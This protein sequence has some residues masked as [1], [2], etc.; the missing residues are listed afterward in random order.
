MADEENTALIAWDA[1]CTANG[2]TVIPELE[3]EKQMEVWQAVYNTCASHAV[4]QKPAIYRVRVKG[5]T[6]SNWLY[7][8]VD[9][10]ILFI[11]D[12]RFECEAMF[13]LDGDR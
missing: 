13:S 2:A 7:I 9:E 4:Y 11:D 3:D 1:Y 12:E 6:P 5:T 10:A 8:S